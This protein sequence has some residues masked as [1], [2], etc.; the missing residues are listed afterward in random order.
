M[1]VEE[2]A[3]LLKE[4]PENIRRW[5]RQG[6]VK[7]TKIGKR[8]D[9]PMD[10]VNRLKNENEHDE[11]VKVKSQAVGQLLASNESTIEASLAMIHRLSEQLVNTLDT[12][13]VSTNE[14]STD[15][16]E[17]RRLYYESDEYTA[18]HSLINEVKELLKVESFNE[19]LKETLKRE[20][21]MNELLKNP[22][23]FTRLFNK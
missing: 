21:K 6:K 13:G 20:E 3:A 7:A 2:L 8:Y 5:I 15:A 14:I 16:Y 18:F 9:V 22:P 17:K 1:I 23:D 19:M 10:E 12:M 11:Y 4:H